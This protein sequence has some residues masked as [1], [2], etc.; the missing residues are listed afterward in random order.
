M[1]CIR[2]TKPDG[3]VW[4][5]PLDA[6]RI[7]IG[8]DADND[9]VLEDVAVSRRHC[10][11]EVEGGQITV[12][13]RGTGN[14]TFL[15]NGPLSEPRPLVEGD[16][17][18]VGPFLIEVVS[19]AA[20]AA[21][22]QHGAVCPV[23][24][25]VRLPAHD[26]H[27]SRRRRRLDTWANE[28]EIAGRPAAMLL[29]GRLLRDAVTQLAADPDPASGTHT[30]VA[31]SRARKTRRKLL[32][33]LGGVGATAVVGLVAVVGLPSLTDTDSGRTDVDVTPDPVDVP[34]V[35]APP[36]AA[37]DPDLVPVQAWVEH[38]VI[39][40]ET[41]DD[42]ARRYGVSVANVARWNA[43]NADDPQIA[44][45]STV[46][47]KP[48]KSPLPQQQILFEL[49][50]DYD[51]KS[52]AT[53]FGVEVDKLRA[54]NPELSELTRGQRV[55]VWIN[56]KP[57]GR[58]SAAFTVPEYDIRPDALSVGRP[59][60]GR[61]E[62]GIQMP[63]SD[64]YERRAPNIMFGSSH[65][66]ETIQTAVA[67]FRR[68]LAFDGVLVLADISRRRG[69]LFDPHKSHQAGRD[70][71]IWMPTL[72][73]VY[74]RNFIG[75][76]RKPKPDEI[77]WFATWGLVRALLETKQI[78]HIF[79]EYR[80]Q[81]KLHHAAKTMGASD[82]ELLTAMQYPRGKS[83][84]G[85]VGHSAGHTGHIHVRFKCGPNDAGCYNDI[86]RRA[87]E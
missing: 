33:V 52:M 50:R 69:G 61:L 14:G 42:I 8:R 2:I 71:D 63:E 43:L 40:A 17:L 20:D 11:L 21:A 28:W 25:I 44:A 23:G 68:D 46:K 3:A 74:K 79:L 49:D 54:Y 22:G 15:N 27:E 26:A 87:Q 10:L 66:I 56:P 60:D 64:L 13:D 35:V 77:D 32:G 72:K 45:G 70:I 29:R 38:S 36:P 67:H 85:L 84:A 57:Y 48:K 59:N 12:K 76:D 1:R 39:P 18:Y 34:V 62:H 65:T 51:W 5:R 41:L 83:V 80:L 82:E 53:R 37:S 58:R 31:R 6:H 4:T 47:V 73:G 81:A 9:L 16:R 55:V 86:S 24:P 78:V 19:I 75:K 30:F 7:N